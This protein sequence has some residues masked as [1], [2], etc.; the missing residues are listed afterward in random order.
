VRRTRLVTA[1]LVAAGVGL[2]FVPIARASGPTTIATPSVESW[3]QPNPTCGLPVV[4]CITS[5]TLPVPL[6]ITLPIA[7][8]TSPYPAGSLHVAVAAGKE[9][10]RTYL[11]FGAALGSLDG[12]V[13][14][15]SLDV[16]LDTN[17]QDG[18]VLPDTA[19]LQVCL[20]TGTLPPGS[21]SYDTPPT[22]LCSTSAPVTYVATPTPHLHADLEA[23]KSNVAYAGGLVLLPDATKLGQTDAWHVVFSAHDRTDASTTPPA[24]LKLSVAAATDTVDV[25]AFVDQPTQDSGLP[26]V[27]PV[28]GTGF[29]A[30]P[31]VP[32]PFQP[33]AAGPAPV[34]QRPVV[35]PQA[36]T[37]TVGYAYPVVWLLPLVFL[38]VVPVAARALAKDLTPQG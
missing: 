24:T 27:A 25:P 26:V 10:A 1:V 14:A 30:P 22:A 2:G 6:P 37:V 4:G 38:V 31:A 12:D 35:V 13:T 32:P 21:G 8:P 17:A 5:A 28:T 33:P 11:S 34:V 29:A 3:Y 19:K 23:L 36:R 18:S 20:F 15:A 9:T 7:I 16:P